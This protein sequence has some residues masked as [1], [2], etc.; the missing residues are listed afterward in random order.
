MWSGCGCVCGEIIRSPGLGACPVS[1]GTRERWFSNEPSK[2]PW[3]RPR[4]WREGKVGPAL[5]LT[6][7]LGKVSPGVDPWAGGRPGA[8]GVGLRVRGGNGR[9][10]E[11]VRGWRGRLQMG[12]ASAQNDDTCLPCLFFSALFFRYILM[13][14]SSV[15]LCGFVNQ[16]VLC[17]KA[18]L[19]DAWL[20]VGFSLKAFETPWCSSRS[21]EGSPCCEEK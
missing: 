16:T 7:R 9:A 5:G 15:C 20:Y 1:P 6:R 13:E 8:A 2:E 12:R 4:E 10:M 3:P 11:G 18:S 14:R 21:D 17:L 19:C